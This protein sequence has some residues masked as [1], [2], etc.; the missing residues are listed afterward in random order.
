MKAEPKTSLGP[1]HRT[2]LGVAWEDVADITKPG[3]AHFADA[4]LEKTCRE[5]LWWDTRRELPTGHKVAFPRGPNGVL[6]PMKCGMAQRM[7]FKIW[8]VPPV[9]HDAIACKFFA[10]AQFPPPIISVDPLDGL[11]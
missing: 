9:P 11:V 6:K 4:T 7:M 10:R 2:R 3:Q 5:C 1:E 8:G